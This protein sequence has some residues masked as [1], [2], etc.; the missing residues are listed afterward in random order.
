MVLNLSIGLC[1]PPVGSVLFVSCAVA[2]TSIHN[3]IRPLLPMYAA[4]II[5]LLLVTYIPAISEV[6]PRAMGF[7]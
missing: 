5:V 7:L 3:I 4:M 6:L 1:T 2:K